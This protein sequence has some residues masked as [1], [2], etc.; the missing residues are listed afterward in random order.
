MC[1]LTA[2]FRQPPPACVSTCALSL[3][4]G[5]ALC[6][7]R[8]ADRPASPG[9]GVTAELTEAAAAAAAAGGSRSR[10]W[11][12][13]ISRRRTVTAPPACPSPGSHSSESVS[14]S[15]SGQNQFFAH[16]VHSRPAGWAPPFVD[17]A[18]FPP[19]LRLVLCRDIFTLCPLIPSPPGTLCGRPLSVQNH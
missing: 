17:Y 5:A 6:D 1:G 4:P 3:P 16:A 2:C 9:G 15:V 11:R 8:R 10:A 18:F 12:V 14:L 13:V 7:S 19:R